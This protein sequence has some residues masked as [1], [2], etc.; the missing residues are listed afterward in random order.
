MTVKDLVCPVCG[1][2][3]WESVYRKRI[4]HPLWWFQRGAARMLLRYVGCRHCGYVTLLPRLSAK[5]YARYY[6]GVPD[7][8]RDVCHKRRAVWRERACFIRD[9]MDGTARG[10]VIEVG[11]GYG[12]FLCLLTA[13]RRR[14]GVEPSRNCWRYVKEHNLPVKYHCCML[15]DVRSACRGLLG[16]ADLVIAA[17]VLEHAVDPRRFV[18]DL[19]ALSRP[20]GY[21]YVEVPS[22]E[23]HADCRQSVYQNIHFGHI[24]QFSVSVLSR[25]CVSE[26]LEPVKVISSAAG[27]Y[28]CVRALYRR[29]GSPDSVLRCFAGHAAAVDAQAELA[30]RKVAGTIRSRSVRTAV[31]WGCGQDLLDALQLLPAASRTRIRQK[32]VLVDMDPAKQRRMFFGMR[33]RDPRSL[34][35]GTPDVVLIATR[36]DITRSHIEE[37]ARQMFPAAKIVSAYALGHGASPASR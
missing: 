17:H 13:F 20:G 12:E 14:I 28:P 19:V 22:I 2:Q 33:I 1:K 36:S 37:A 29:M 16:S 15:E 24:S 31:V 27:N 25:L 11:P 8:W 23:A 4:L 9:H 32:A 26:S 34:R 5:D 6:T 18:R 35:T 10:T 7:L 3:H 21:V 30:A